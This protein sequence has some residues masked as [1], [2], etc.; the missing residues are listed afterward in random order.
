MDSDTD[1]DLHDRIERIWSTLMRTPPPPVG[2]PRDQ[3]RHTIGAL[4][5]H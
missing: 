2:P 1:T 4:T 5:A 3:L